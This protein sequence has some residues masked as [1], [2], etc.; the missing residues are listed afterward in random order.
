[1][2]LGPSELSATNH[3]PHL[4]LAKDKLTVKYTGDGRHE[5]G[6]IQVSVAGACATSS[7][8]CATRTHMYRPVVHTRSCHRA[9]WYA[10]T[11][12]IVHQTDALHRQCEHSCPP[13]LVPSPLQ[14]NRPVPTRQL[15]FYFEVT[16]IDSGDL[17][18]IGIGF[19]PRD[20]KLTRQPGCAQGLLHS[21]TAT[22]LRSRVA[23]CGRLALGKCDV[24]CPLHV[25]FLSVSL[26]QHGSGG[27]NA[28]EPS[29]KKFAPLTAVHLYQ[30]C[31]MPTPTP[32]TG[33]EYQGGRACP[34]R[35]TRSNAHRHAHLKTCRRTTPA[36]HLAQCLPTCSP[37]APLDPM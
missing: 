35:T 5:V 37:P 24:L 16:I 6:A 34:I 33:S 23:G 14:A 9:C 22:S 3:G 4:E 7:G 17:G 15:V 28:H 27:C 10:K 8:R 26:R 19:T 31:V 29:S 36:A 1:M 30:C 32:T 18:K 25:Y 11:G 2:E 21:C 20:V 13:L 12:P